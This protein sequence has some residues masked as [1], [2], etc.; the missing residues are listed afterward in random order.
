MIDP[1]EMLVDLREQAKD[2][3]ATGDY[4]AM[5]LGQKFLA[6]DGWL[7]KRGFPPKEWAS[8][9]TTTTANT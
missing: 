2:A 1:D 4:K 9:T 8:W 7:T 6:L 3:I 5:V